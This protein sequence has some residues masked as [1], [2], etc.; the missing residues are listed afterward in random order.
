MR[1]PFMKTTLVSMA[2]MPTEYE[3]LLNLEMQTRQATPMWGTT[4]GHLSNPFT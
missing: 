1:G 2:L 4:P 3:D